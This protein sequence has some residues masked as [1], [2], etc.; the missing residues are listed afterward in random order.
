MYKLKINQN[1]RFLND[2]E[3]KNVSLDQD[4]DIMNKMY[5]LLLDLNQFAAFDPVILNC[6]VSLQKEEVNDYQV[7]V[8]IKQN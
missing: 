4:Q 8:A 7:R 6:L 3:N 1:F 2:L 5:K